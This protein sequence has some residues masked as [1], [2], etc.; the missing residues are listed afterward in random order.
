MGRLALY[1]VPPGFVVKDPT[2]WGVV[3]G[4]ALN[5]PVA[6]FNL[7]APVSVFPGTGNASFNLAASS[8]NV[9]STNTAAITNQTCYFLFTQSND[10]AS[11]SGGKYISNVNAPV[12]PGET[13]GPIG[14]VISVS[15]QLDLVPGPAG[16]AQADVWNVI[17]DQ[18]G[19][20]PS[21]DGIPGDSFEQLGSASG[22]A[23]TL[24]TFLNSFV[25]TDFELQ[26]TAGLAAPGQFGPNVPEP[27]SLLLW[28]L[29]AGG[30]GFFVYL[31]RRNGAVVAR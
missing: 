12:N 29:M 14:L 5:K 7:S 13:L 1:A 22:R 31:C 30:A 2:T 20:L 19:G 4:G 18:L 17:A 25:G 16:Q 9:L 24:T 26:I 8:L 21:V 11:L 3:T 28:S 10:I 23:F 6:V 27:A 15:D